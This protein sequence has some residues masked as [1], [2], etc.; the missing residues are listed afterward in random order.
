MRKGEFIAEVAERTHGSAGDPITAGDVEMVIN[1]AL[2]VITDTLR[3]GEDV[4]I[5]GF[6]QFSVS[7]RAA[8]NGVNPATGEP[9]AIPASRV[10]KFKPGK[11]LKE[12]VNY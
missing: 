2:A 8:R 11:P 12:A 4:A 10:P 7:D 3:A 9:I 5:T 1:A 6:G